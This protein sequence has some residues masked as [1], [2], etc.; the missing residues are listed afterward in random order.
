MLTHVFFSGVEGQLAVCGADGALI[1]QEQD[2]LAALSPFIN[3]PQTGGQRGF[4]SLLTDRIESAD[5]LLPVP[6][7]GSVG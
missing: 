7:S 4:I 6:A 5:L 2:Y 3:I 1:E